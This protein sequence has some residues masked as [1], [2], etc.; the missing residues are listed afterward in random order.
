MGLSKGVDGLQSPAVH[1]ALLSISKF[2]ND[3]GLS[4]SVQTLV[5]EVEEKGG[6]NIQCKGHSFDADKRDSDLER[7]L[8]AALHA[9]NEEN[10]LNNVQAPRPLNTTNVFLSHTKRDHDSRT[11]SSSRGQPP[12]Q[13][14][15][16]LFSICR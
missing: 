9:Q 6:K 5:S 13:N 12:A 1:E 15:G 4:S 7:L 16:K 8:F 10:I 3:L 14:N 11:F 2:L